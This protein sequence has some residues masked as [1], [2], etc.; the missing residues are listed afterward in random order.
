[1]KHFKQ[2]N[3]N[4]SR[5]LLIKNSKFK[6]FP[7]FN[8][9]SDSTINNDYK[10]NIIQQMNMHLDTKMLGLIAKMN[11]EN[12]YESLKLEYD[13]DKKKI[14]AKTLK[15]FY[16]SDTYY[17][18]QNHM[19]L[20]NFH[21]KLNRNYTYDAADNQL[22]HSFFNKM[23]TR[24]RKVIKKKENHYIDIL[25]HGSNSPKKM[26]DIIQKKERPKFDFKILL[27]SNSDI[28]AYLKRKADRLNLNDNDKQI[29]SYN[30]KDEYSRTM[31]RLLNKKDKIISIKKNSEKI[32]FISKGD[33]LKLIFE[34][35][36]NRTSMINS[37][38]IKIKN[39]FSINREIK[40]K[41]M[42]NESNSK[43]DIIFSSYKNKTNKDDKT[44]TLT[45]STE[46]LNMNLLKNNIIKVSKINKNKSLLKEMEKDPKSFSLKKEMNKTSIDNLF[47]D[48]I[49]PIKIKLN[50]NERIQYM[51]RLNKK[52]F[53]KVISLFNEKEKKI[54]RKYT[55][56]NKL[57][58]DL[59]NRG[60]K[61]VPEDRNKSAKKNKKL[62]DL[63][64]EQSLKK[65]PRLLYKEWNEATSLFHFPL[66]NR[67]IYKSQKKS[68][69][70]DE[71][72]AN[73]R[74]EYKDKV[75]RNRQESKRK[76]DGKRIIKKLND[77]YEIARLI[78][79][80][81]KLKEKQR[82]N[83]KFENYEI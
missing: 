10:Q 36:K 78:E 41:K 70:I 17:S 81:N 75:R 83:D 37:P 1:M 42:I 80:L 51:N 68:D 27:K 65:T 2:I 61:S 25:F 49:F 53:D 48:E 33:D 55:K 69:D 45:R 7:S 31:S 9:L 76:I 46:S 44:L 59:K 56:I 4:K 18:L 8:R 82:K 40:E 35:K 14:L 54:E 29:Q 43:K 15:S 19:N 16:N 24:K 34:D 38:N 11:D 5:N 47:K 12:V 57:I 67:V 28:E 72:K 3:I 52:K 62:I 64:K 71:I 66:I 30:L 6:G 20:K 77:K 26:K 74:K 23:K 73:L 32:P 63:K 22:I 39:R 21:D 58:T 50:E 60:N 79:Y 13:E